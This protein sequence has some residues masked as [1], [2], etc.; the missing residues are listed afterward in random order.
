MKEKKYESIPFGD[1]NVLRF[2][3][4]TSLYTPRRIY[5]IKVE[6]DY[7]LRCSKGFRKIK[8]TK[9]EIENISITTND[10]DEREKAKWCL[11]YIAEE[12]EW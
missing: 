2:V 7:V 1:D 12:S 9:N 5:L 11:E 6:I 10:S 4:T 8:V 3:E